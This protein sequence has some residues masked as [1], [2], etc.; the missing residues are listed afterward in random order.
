M[1]KKK[2]QQK[3]NDEDF[4]KRLKEE[5]LRLSKIPNEDKLYIQKA[6]IDDGSSGI[7]GT[8]PESKIIKFK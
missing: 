3:K 8:T 2:R 5:A 7:T 4:G 1:K 6:P